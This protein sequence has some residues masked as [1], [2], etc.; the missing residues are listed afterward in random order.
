MSNVMPGLL[1]VG[2]IPSR[3]GLRT[4]PSQHRVDEGYAVPP[5]LAAGERMLAG[6]GRRPLATLGTTH[7][8][9]FGVDDDW[10]RTSWSDIASVGWSRADRHLRVLTW[11]KLRTP[12]SLRIPADARFAAFADERVKSTQL[13]RTRVEVL[14]GVSAT[15]FAVR[16]H[17]DGQVQWR[18]VLDRRDL[19]NDHAVHDACANIITEMRSLAGC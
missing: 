15:V 9:Y 5:P 17:A 11:A 12:S 10:Q 16:S 3:A 19:A 7:A 1:R 4:R 6:S 18:L 8:L 13:L 2:R 14:A